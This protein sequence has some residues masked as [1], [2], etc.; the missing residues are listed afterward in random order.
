MKFPLRRVALTSLALG[1]CSTGLAQDTVPIEYYRPLR[2]SV[3][4]GVRMIGGN[5]KVGFKN[6]G[7][8]PMQP[9]PA[10]TGTAA[11]GY[12]NGAI[13]TDKDRAF[14]A[15]STSGVIKDDNDVV[16]KRT[17]TEISRSPAV[18][19]RYQ[20]IQV[21]TTTDAVT[22]AETIERRILED[23][24]EYLSDFT[25]N[26][27]YTSA[28]QYNSGTGQ[29]DMSN[30]GVAPSPTSNASAESDRSSGVEMQFAYVI[31]RYKRF[32]WGVNFS[33]GISDLNAKTRQQ[34][35]ADLLT[36]TDRYNLGPG[37]FIGGNGYDSDNDFETI[38]TMTT[39]TATPVE[40]SYA[41]ER[42][43]YLNPNGTRILDNAITAGG[44]DVLG[45]WQIKG[46]YYLLRF[47]PTA[48][49]ELTKNWTVS[50]GAGVAGAFVGSRFIAEE[51]FFLNDLTAPIRTREENEKNA[52]VG[53]YYADVNIERWLTVRTGFYLGY[54]TEKLG[55]YTHT[56]RGRKAEVDFGSSNGFRFGVITRF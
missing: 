32:E 48:R 44:A 1:V 34:I 24:L 15:S 17:V 9:P 29:V 46:A 56:L 42:P 40:Y 7:N 19:G 14:T 54:S 26:W 28:S 30:Y 22:L 41:F 33:A 51:S 10:F 49:F 35:R 12:Y 52:A 27:S 16:I 18:N 6:L 13:E 55:D 53:G 36:T 38:P 45:Y 5:A 25:R 2:N 31:K 8:I 3:S 50:V 47:G 20:I 37:A 43:R 23:N 4:V 21:V 39:G 11:R